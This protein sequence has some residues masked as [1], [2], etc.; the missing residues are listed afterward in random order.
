MKSFYF[1]TLPE[2][3]LHPFVDSLPA[4][5]SEIKFLIKNHNEKYNFE[6]ISYFLNP[7]LND[8]KPCGETQIKNPEIEFIEIYLEKILKVLQLF[9]FSEE[10]LF[11]SNMS[12]CEKS[13]DKSYDCIDKFVIADN[14][15]SQF[16]TRLVN[17]GNP[18]ETEYLFLAKTEPFYLFNKI[19]LKRTA[20]DTT[21]DSEYFN[22]ETLFI[23]NYEKFE[24]SVSKATDKYLNKDIVYVG[25]PE[26]NKDFIR[27]LNP[28][29]LF[30]IHRYFAKTPL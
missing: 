18:S 8:Y 10:T 15:H 25:Y 30:T 5:K 3:P 1:S 26:I 20:I 7:Y 16:R 6:H 27:F 28:K 4:I 29:R 12:G 9:K 19:L 17:F 11:I 24:V 13:I 14:I 21:S 22:D 23:C 2:T